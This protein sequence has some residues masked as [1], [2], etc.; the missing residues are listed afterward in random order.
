MGLLL[1]A[2]VV[3][4]MV[5]SQNGDHNTLIDRIMRFAEIIFDCLDF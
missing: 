3:Y 2:A 1:A 4:T 5:S